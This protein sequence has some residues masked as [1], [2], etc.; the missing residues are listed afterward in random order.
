MK[1][2]PTQMP[3]VR[4]GLTTAAPARTSQALAGNSTPSMRSTYPIPNPLVTT[5]T[6]MYAPAASTM[7][8]QISVAGFMGVPPASS[9]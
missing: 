1:S 6:T 4:E 2:A 5:R 9:R 8:S 3:M 7:R